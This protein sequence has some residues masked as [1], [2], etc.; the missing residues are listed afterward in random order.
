[1]LPLWVRTL[2]ELV[3]GPYP[4]GYDTINSYVPFM[5]D[6]GSGKYS[7]S[8]NPL[9]GGWI[10]YVLFGATYAGTHLDPIVITK[11]AAPLLFGFLGLSEFYFA[12]TVLSWGQA[13]SMLLVA[14][15]SV[16]FLLLRMS[17]DLLRN[18]LGLSLLL[19]AISWKPRS[20][21]RATL[22]MMAL[23]VWLVVATHLLAG[24][25]LVGILMLT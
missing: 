7:S 12:R 16:D 17:W 19:I 5:L 14:I 10:T 6:W 13:K 20:E 15:G 1:M 8:F 2:P 21:R 9:I 25:L 18:T 22:G 23:L 11:L 3:A 24:A 4:I